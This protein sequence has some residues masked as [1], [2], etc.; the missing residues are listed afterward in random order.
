MQATAGWDGDGGD[1][2]FGDEDPDDEDAGADSHDSND[3]KHVPQQD[4]GQAPD[5]FLTCVECW[6]SSKDVPST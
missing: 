6:A 4:V 2:I 5:E 3:A 1:G